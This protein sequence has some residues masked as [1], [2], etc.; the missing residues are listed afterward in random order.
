[1]EGAK[2]KIRIYTS[3]AEQAEDEIAMVLQ[4]TPEQRIAETMQLILRVYG[5]TQEE[6]DSKRGKETHNNN[7][8]RM[9]IA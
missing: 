2:K 7:K 4:Q 9:N 3:F 8:E 5:T 1:M 6:L